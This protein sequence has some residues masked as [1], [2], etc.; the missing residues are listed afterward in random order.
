M[1]TW[2]R[3]PNATLF[4]FAFWCFWQDHMFFAGSCHPAVRVAASAVVL[5]FLCSSCSQLFVL[6]RRPL[7][8]FCRFTHLD[9]HLQIRDDFSQDSRY[10]SQQPV[11]RAQ[12][13]SLSLDFCFE[14]CH[15]FV[16]PKTELE[17]GVLFWLRLPWVSG[18][19]K[20]QF[21][22]WVFCSAG[23]TCVNRAP[24]RNSWNERFKLPCFNS[25][26]KVESCNSTQN[27]NSTELQSYS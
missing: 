22:F 5:K 16:E 3:P 19:W 23:F 7:A 4:V 12:K 15:E 13:L 2:G 17:F 26:L 8:V 20:T 21:E 1:G 25:E 9:E 14:L 10:L 18:A 11:C 6:S 24:K 27:S